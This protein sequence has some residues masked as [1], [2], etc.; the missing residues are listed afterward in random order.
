MTGNK[1]VAVAAINEGVK[2]VKPCVA[3]HGWVSCDEPSSLNPK[4]ETIV[5]IS[6]IMYDVIGLIST[7]DKTDN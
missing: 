7:V 6:V 2:W 5:V 3:I 4:G 1:E